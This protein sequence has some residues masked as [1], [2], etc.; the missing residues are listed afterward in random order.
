MD[1]TSTLHHTADH[2]PCFT[3]L[4]VFNLIIQ[5]KPLRN[6][7][8]SQTDS[9]TGETRSVLQIQGNMKSWSQCFLSYGTKA[10]FQKLSTLF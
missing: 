2:S 4:E 10:F 7:K 6:Q 1:P 3:V 9:N 8:L 5:V